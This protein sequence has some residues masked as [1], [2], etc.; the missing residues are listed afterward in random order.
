LLRWGLI[1]F[2]PKLAL[3]INFPNLHLWRS[4]D[5]RYELLL[6]AWFCIFNFFYI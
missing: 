5:Y 6:L 1:N 3:N 2:L 4:W